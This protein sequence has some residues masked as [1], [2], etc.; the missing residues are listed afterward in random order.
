M[1]RF[2]MAA[3]ALAPLA[4]C[5][6]TVVPAGPATRV[7]GIEPFT[8][9]PLPWRLRVTTAWGP[10][11]PEPQPSGPR[12][13]EALVMRDG[14]RLPLRVWRPEEP[15]R[16]V[17]LALHGLGDHG[18]NF[19]Q[20]GAPLLNA[21]GALVY[22]YDQR[23]FG[24]APHRGFWAGA[25]TLRDDALEAIR[26]LR[27]RHPDLPLWLLGESMGAA[28]AILAGTAPEPP[29]VAGYLLSAPAI[30][31]R[32][33][34]P[35]LFRGTLWGVERTVPA[36]GLVAGA[37]GIA[38]SDNQEALRRFGNDPLTLRV[39]RVDMAT[40][41]VDLMDAA[42]AA[43]PA[44][45]RN[46]RGPAPTMVFVGARDRV[47][48]AHVQRRVYRE[49]PGLRVAQYPE[50]WHLLLRDRIRDQVARDMLAFIADPAAPLPAEV[51]AR[52]WLSEREGP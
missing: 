49:L 39:L 3:L 46:P 26:L 47:V 17:V 13:E 52:R 27:A 33:R 43:L 9:P 35:A 11:P 28:V 12:P 50:G 32:A 44:C 14:A 6:P 41:V 40:G 36:V 21:G 42:L 8:P 31:G 15:P 25:A 10:P 18:G 7:A 51:A 16:F 22:A 34:M 4:A 1:R 2:L 29:E 5:A 30:W 23:G 24:W 37:G 20:D 38:A 45:C 19:M 48:P